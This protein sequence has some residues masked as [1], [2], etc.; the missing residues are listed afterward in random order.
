MHYYFLEK[1]LLSLTESWYKGIF[2]KAIYKIRLLSC[3]LFTGSENYSNPDYKRSC[4]LT[5]LGQW[6]YSDRGK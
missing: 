5:V 6:L 3:Y 1:H 4:K 2:D